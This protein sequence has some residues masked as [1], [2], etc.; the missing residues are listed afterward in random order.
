MRPGSASAQLMTN[1][2]DSRRL[3]NLDLARRWCCRTVL[4][5]SPAALLAPRLSDGVAG[6]GMASGD[7]SLPRRVVVYKQIRCQDV[8]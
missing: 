4:L 1:S 6:A 8:L 5:S 7:V 2:P 3:G